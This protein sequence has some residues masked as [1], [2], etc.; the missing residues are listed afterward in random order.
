VSGQI[1]QARIGAAHGEIHRIEPA[2]VDERRP[3]RPPVAGA[4]YAIVV[5]E[6]GDIRVGGAERERM[7]I[8]G[9]ERRQPLP[10]PASRAH[11]QQRGQHRAHEED[12]EDHPQPRRR[13]TRDGCPSGRS[14]RTLPATGGDGTPGH[15]VARHPDP[16]APIQSPPGTALHLRQRTDPPVRHRHRCGIGWHL[17]RHYTLQSYHV[18]W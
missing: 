4:E 13:P 2:A 10:S 16:L 6:E 18:Q 3:G 7:E 12:T 11:D 1:E 5:A 8:A 9:L 14:H 17:H 15:R